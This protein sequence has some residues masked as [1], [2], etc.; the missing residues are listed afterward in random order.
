MSIAEVC[1]EKGSEIASE[2]QLGD[3]TEPIPDLFNSL[4]YFPEEV[5]REREEW[6]AETFSVNI[7][8]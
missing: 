7:S 8:K 5:Q 3:F 4:T 2:C 1:P 6:V